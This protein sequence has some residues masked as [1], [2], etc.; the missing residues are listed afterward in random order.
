[1]SA[2]R[3]S[4]DLRR[5]V[6]ERAALRCEYC[7]IPENVVMFLHE[8]DHIYAEK[9]GGDTTVENLC[10]SCVLCNGFK[11]TDLSSI[12]PDTGLIER[13]FHPRRDRWNDPLLLSH[14][15]IEAI[16]AIGRVTSRL[17]RFN[18]EDRIRERLLY[19]AAGLYA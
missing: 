6:R 7:L 14:G 9:H 5:K 4:A 18:D 17:L 19:I 3:V 12:D 1:V 13:L 11:G 10:L 8:M 16:T 15:R 2:S